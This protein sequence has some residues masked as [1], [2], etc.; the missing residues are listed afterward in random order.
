MS[1]SFSNLER[2]SVQTGPHY[3]PI[4]LF[5]PATRLEATFSLACDVWCHMIAK[6]S[7]S[8]CGTCSKLSLNGA[9][10]SIRF[11]HSP[12]TAVFY[13]FWQ[14]R[15]FSGALYSVWLL[16]HIECSQRRAKCIGVFVAFHTVTHLFKMQ[17]TS[18]GWFQSVEKKNRF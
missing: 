18:H 5:A 14:L 3:W 10:V 15:T 8:R 6:E 7:G 13:C 12:G 2:D 4:W 17:S 16:H 1:D 9:S 11:L